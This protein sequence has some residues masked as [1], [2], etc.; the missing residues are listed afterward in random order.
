MA[1]LASLPPELTKMV[2]EELDLLD[3]TSRHRLALVSRALHDQLH[4]AS[5]IPPRMSREDWYEFNNEFERFAPRRPTTLACSICMTLLPP[6]SF[7]D[8]QAKKTAYGKRF[9]LACGIRAG[10]YGK[11]SF[12]IGN[13][14][15]FVC[16]TGHHAMPVAQEDDC[17]ENIVYRNNRYYG[18]PLGDPESVPSAAV[19]AASRVDPLGVCSGEMRWCR[20]CWAQH[21]LTVRQARP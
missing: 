1:P 12:R 21:K 7:S 18:S 4:A 6:A 11:T 3:G 17:P 14:V 10:K 16:G 20:P 9:C 15:S 8:N 2:G 5:G 19:I 13:I